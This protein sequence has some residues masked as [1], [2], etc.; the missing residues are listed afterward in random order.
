MLSNTPMLMQAD[1][2]ASLGFMI[3][4]SCVR[5]RARARARTCRCQLWQLPRV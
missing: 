1:G 3:P 5:P 4:L 2:M